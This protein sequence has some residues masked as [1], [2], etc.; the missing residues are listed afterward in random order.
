MA[1]SH[2]GLIGLGAMGTGIATSIARSGISLSI[3]DSDD[4]RLNSINNS[5]LLH[6]DT[7][8]TI[9]AECDLI[10][11]CVPSATQIDQLLSGSSLK[12]G[13]C[14][15]DL[16][17]SD[18]RITQKRA[19]RLLAENNAHQLDAAMSGGAKGAAA[20]TLTLMVGGDKQILEN[21]KEVLSSFANQIFYIGEAGKG[22]LMKLF[23]NAVCHGNFLLLSEICIK[24]EH[25][26]LDLAQMIE[27][28]NCSNARSYISEK[29]F[30]DHILSGTFD[31]RSTPS[32]LKKD[33]SL[34][35]DLLKIDGVEESYLSHS[36]RLLNM[37]DTKFENDDFML[38]YPQLKQ[39]LKK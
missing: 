17:S 37:L 7:S 29:R 22:Q 26:G 6:K 19:V 13:S 20:G 34:L 39:I 18:P 15:I 11:F 24:G 2:I 9:I 3:N 12:S 27:V 30:P 25:Y 16:T 4:A 38:I 36:L 35:D 31:G 33:L 28:F 8:E 21:H 5:P 14:V 1:G 23:H 32:N 10:L